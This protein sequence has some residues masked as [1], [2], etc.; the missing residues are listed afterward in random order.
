MTHGSDAAAA[1]DIEAHLTPEQTLALIDS[2]RARVDAELD[3][4][5]RRLYAAWGAAW[6][7]GFGGLYATSVDE[8]LVDVSRGAALGAHFVL[9]VAA[10]AYTA[11]HVSRA[12]RGV[13]G[14]SATTGAM[15]GW[16]WMLGF[17]SLPVIIAAV[18]RVGAPEPV[19]DLLWTTLPGL[20]V[21]V[22]YMM[23]GALWQDW[24]GFA[25]GVW[26][27]VS[28]GL[29]ALAG[30]PGIYL[31]MSL[32]GGGGFLLA[33]GAFA[34]LRARHARQSAQAARAP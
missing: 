15:Y 1:P 3:V 14:V 5:P 11:V 27:L 4:D 32:A 24:S 26:I 7:V 8:P 22:L 30:L 23:A 16:S 28:T 20:L 33:A 2:Q 19:L 18:E 29:G 9:L 13:R 34:L 17:A 21:G 10:M 12:T 25:L 6:L 31:V